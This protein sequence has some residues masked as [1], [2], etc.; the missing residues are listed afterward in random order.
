MIE[1]NEVDL[2]KRTTFKIGGIA[3]HFFIPES[4][5]ELMELI[6]KLK[7]E[8]KLWYILSGGSN[9]LI[10]DKKRYENVIYMEKVDTTIT[11]IEEGYFYIGASN[12]IQKI[13]REV[14]KLGYGGFEELFC[15]PA[16]FGGIIYMNAGIGGRNNVKFN[17]SDFISKV[18]VF[19]IESEKIILL[20]KEDCNFEYRKSIFKNDG[21]IILGAEIKLKKQKIEDSNNKIEKRIEYCKNNQDWGKGCFGSC[22]SNFSPK[23][24]KIVSLFYRNKKGVRMASN[25]SNWLVN[26]GT[27]S[28]KDAITIIKRCCFLHRILH[29]DI[30]R[31]VIIWK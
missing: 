15:L 13:I 6:K 8:N 21:F 5:V 11:M 2:A 29:R 24:L 19:D 9:L 12:R 27:G 10:D 1:K 30:E 25:N 20:N 18:K 22:F 3:E 31:E 14:N 4:D 17:I 7:K 23:I 26:D 28:Y 16:M